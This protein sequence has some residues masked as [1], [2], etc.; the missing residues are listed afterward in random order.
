MLA[1]WATSFLF[2]FGGKD[3]QEHNAR[4]AVRSAK[5]KIAGGRHREGFFGKHIISM[6][7]HDQAKVTVSRLANNLGGNNALVSA[8][9]FRTGDARTTFGTTALIFRCGTSTAG[10]NREK[11]G[12]QT[13]LNILIKVKTC[14]Q[15]VQPKPAFF[16]FF[17]FSNT[18]EAAGQ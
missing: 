5:T 11:K 12:T 14:P 10:L 8:C 3:K 9:A 15:L 13:N 16:F 18:S 6:P 2:V 4:R 1:P 17:S 7:R